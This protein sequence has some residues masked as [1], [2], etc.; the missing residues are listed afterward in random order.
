[1]SFTYFVNVEMIQNCNL[2]KNFCQDFNKVCL[3]LAKM[4][5]LKYH[6]YFEETYKLLN[7]RGEQLDI[8]SNFL[9][10]I[11]EESTLASNLMEDI[12][13]EFS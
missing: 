9:E 10:I 13:N 12:L 4:V 6:E 7:S 5:D 1:L 2:F 3:F 8:Y 11:N